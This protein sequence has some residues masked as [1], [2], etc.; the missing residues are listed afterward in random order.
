MSTEIVISTDS[1]AVFGTARTFNMVWGFLKQPE[2][3][4]NVEAIGWKWLPLLLPGYERVGVKVKG[5]HGQ[6]G[7]IHDAHDWFDRLKLLALNQMLIPNAQLIE[8]KGL[9]DYVLVHSPQ[10]IKLQEKRLIQ[11]LSGKINTFFVENHLHGGALGSAK[12][13][14]I[15]LVEYGVN[16][17]LMID[18]GHVSNT[19]Y[20]PENDFDSSFPNAIKTIQRNI[21]ELQT[22]NSRIPIAFHLPIGDSDCLNMEKMEKQHWKMIAE[23]IQMVPDTF[24]V[25]E[26]QQYFTRSFI[27]TPKWAGLQRVE[28]QRKIDI[29]VDNE[30]IAL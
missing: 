21:I 29:L 15:S 19:E 5:I 7:G 12:E 18:F 2:K 4:L 23:T 30:V 26:N 8:K 22:H 10:V 16:A 17:G 24:V 9:V 1:T 3:P 25:I 28:N 13:N 11:K 27:L 6:T 20:D 14:V